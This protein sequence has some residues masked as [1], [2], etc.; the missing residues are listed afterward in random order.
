MLDQSQPPSRTDC[1]DPVPLLLDQI[2]S[3]NDVIR[4]GAVRAAAAVAADDPRVRAALLACLLDE[5]PDVRTDAMDSLRLCAQPEDAPVLRKSLM[6]D[7]VREV[8]HAAILTLAALGDVGSIPVLRQ[9]ALSRASGDIAW[10]DETDAWDDWLDVQVMAIEA[11]GHLKAT[12]AIEDILAARDDEEGQVLDGPVFAA[13][14]A[15]GSEGATWLLSIAQSEQGLSRK[16][17]LESLAEMTPS[18]LE[19][20]ADYVLEDGA[21]D[22][23]RLAITW[24]APDDK[25]LEAL[26][27]RDPEAG[28][29][30]E[31]LARI[32]PHLPDLAIS[33]LSDNSPAVQ[34]VALDH[35]ALP[36][37]AKLHATVTENAFAWCRVGDEKL[38]SAAARLLPDLAPKTSAPALLALAQDTARPLA[39]RLE[40]VKAI[41]RL[42]DEP[43]TERL[44]GL[45][46]N[47]SQQVRA[48]ALTCLTTLC[49]QGD[50]V[51]GEALA[52]AMAGTLLSAEHAVVAH[53]EAGGPDVTMP[54]ADAP[55]RGHL[56]I[57][58]EGDIIETDAAEA[59][60]AIRSTL[61]VI[62]QAGRETPPE[63]IQATDTPEE[64]PAKRRHRRPVE[65]PEAVADDLRVLALG[66]AGDLDHPRIADAVLGALNDAEETLR[67]VAWR[68]LL[69]RARTGLRGAET[70]AQA[71]AGL[72]DETPAIRSVAADILA[73]DA[74]AARGL[75]ACL[76]DSDALLR[77]VAVRHAA[78]NV[79]AVSALADPAKMVRG[80]ALDRL[81]D[82][83]DAVHST[84]IFD[85]L[86]DA[87]HIDSL[88]EACSRSDH[89]LT[90]SIQALAQ[91]DLAPRKAHVLLEALA[92]C[93]PTSGERSPQGMTA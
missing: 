79:E 91:K 87:D 48:V 45:L 82:D 38:A 84:P 8:K 69:N 73:L 68:A 17:A 60:Q 58:R 16:R 74:E 29:R 14:A 44:T 81:L 12:D 37:E 47:E 56:R 83:P 2:A 52:V 34:A 32:A 41:A 7:P 88:A 61:E 43:A 85:A 78:T 51:A 65:G 39:A 40:A 3:P 75:R 10:E 53:Q 13:L 6:G 26:S 55:P 50:A 86:S 64:T 63:P 76:E 18:L 33:A 19:D 42:E 80:A 66:I 21:A 11:L 59:P 28:I 35:L 77:A 72:K 27:L 71:T 30:A 49:R 57:S 4:T 23:R 46:G 93:T 89:I 92:A 70:L 90:R 24:L 54:K 5:D 36:L 1:P 31:T 67:L 62:Q 22:V 20:Y 25:R 9:L 15:M